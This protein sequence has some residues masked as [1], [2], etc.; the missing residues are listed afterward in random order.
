ML[1]SKNR[2]ESFTDGLMVIM[3][4]IMVLEVNVTNNFT[5]EGIITLLKNI[6][7]FFTSFVIV[8]FFWHLHHLSFHHVEIITG[9]IVWKNFIFLFFIALIPVVTKLVIENQKNIIAFIIYVILFIFVYISFLILTNEILTNTKETLE[10][11]VEARVSLAL[12]LLS[13]FI[14]LIIS[15]IVLVLQIMYNIHLHTFFGYSFI[16]II[17]MLV[18]ILIILGKDDLTRPAK[19]YLKKKQKK[20][21]GIKEK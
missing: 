5:F 15:L 17:V 10:D 4:T 9:K 2:F 1:L 21:L 16:G 20:F 18:V 3:I 14:L 19:K 11:V 8:G 6:F 12:N 13:L 7:I